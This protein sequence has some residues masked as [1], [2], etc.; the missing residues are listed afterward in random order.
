MTANNCP[1]CHVKYECCTCT[2][3]ATKK[4]TTKVTARAV[5]RA[6]V[7]MQRAGLPFAN[8]AK[9]IEGQ[10]IDTGRVNLSPYVNDEAQKEYQRKY[11]ARKIG[12]K[13]TG[14]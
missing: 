14:P 12:A 10:H 1:R 3:G 5:F 9:H 7:N 8:G 13:S 2:P 6:A 11:R 4:G